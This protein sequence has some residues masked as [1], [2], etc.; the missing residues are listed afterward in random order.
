MS[1]ILAS[2]ICLC[3]AFATQAYAATAADL[4]GSWSVDADAT[5]DKMKAQPQ[6]A[7]AKPE[8]VTQVKAMF[9][10]MS[11]EITK[12]KMISS[13]AGQKKEE[14]YTVSKGEGDSLVTESTD[15]VGKKEKSKVEFLK[16]GSL[17]LTNLD[18]PAQ[19]MVLKK[20]AAKK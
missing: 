11:Y 4:I 8:Q 17:L 3:L 5:W 16:D 7:A 20:A 14:T 12:D 2:L 13:M 15:A 19:Q 10:S 1:R 18:N 6:F 9:G